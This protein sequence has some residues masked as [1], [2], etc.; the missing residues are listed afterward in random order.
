MRKSILV[1]LLG[2]LVSFAAFAGKDM[3]YVHSAKAHI[4]S[5][6]SMSSPDMAMAKRGDSMKMLKA[7]GMWYNVNYK[8]HTGWVSKLFVKTQKPIG[9]ADL[10]KAAAMSAEKTSRKRS[11]AY[12]VSGA[13][14]GLTAN[15]R[16]RGQREQY[17]SD[18]QALKEMEE[19]RLPA[20][21]V[22]KFRHKAGLQ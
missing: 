10:F 14:R 13:T 19:Y 16:V 15:T 8:G 11:S 1:G 20:N 17:R 22:N 6:T 9:Q 2:L 7:Q 21:V 4:K 18:F 3:L 5:Q 12:A